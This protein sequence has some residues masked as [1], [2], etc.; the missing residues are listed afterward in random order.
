MTTVNVPGVVIP[1]RTYKAD[2]VPQPDQ[3]VDNEFFIRIDPN[4]KHAFYTRHKTT[5]EII[6][7]YEAGSAVTDIAD[8]AVYQSILNL[9]LPSSGDFALSVENG[10][11]VF[12]PIKQTIINNYY[13]TSEV[14][15][16]TVTNNNTYVVESEY[17][18]LLKQLPEGQTLVSDGKGG[19]HPVNLKDITGTTI[20]TQTLVSQRDEAPSITHVSYTKD[21]GWQSNCAVMKPGHYRVVVQMRAV[22]SGGTGIVVRAKITGSNVPTRYTIAT[23][24][25]NTK[26][27]TGK[28]TAGY[29]PCKSVSY[30]ANGTETFDIVVDRNGKVI[31][32]VVDNNGNTFPGLQ[33]LDGNI[34]LYKKKVI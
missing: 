19:W 12:K 8:S 25:N 2:F 1:K 13:T 26:P 31:V 22:A 17:D 18:K 16:E 29:I 23:A 14:V 34:Q 3:L 21:G 10:Q 4:G 11:L 7:L 9:D 5:N 24:K 33:S 15:K 28:P 6:L 27:L 30:V 20:Q 32:E